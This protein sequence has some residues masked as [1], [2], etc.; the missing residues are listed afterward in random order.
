MVGEASKE[1]VTTPSEVVALDTSDVVEN[2]EKVISPDSV[3]E[4]TR[5]VGKA[6]SLVDEV[7]TTPSFKLL[8]VKMLDG[9]EIS[10]DGVA[11]ADSEVV[12]VGYGILGTGLVYSTLEVDST[13]VANIVEVAVPMT[14]DV[15]S[16]KE[17]VGTNVPL[18]C[19]P[20]LVSVGRPI[21]DVSIEVKDSKVDEFSVVV[22][23]ISDVLSLTVND[24]REIWLL[25]VSVGTGPSEVEVTIPIAEDVDSPKEV[26]CDTS[27]E[28]ST[29]TDVEEDSSEVVT[30]T[31]GKSV[32][33]EPGSLFNWSAEFLGSFSVLRG[34]GTSR[35]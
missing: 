34:S 23:T 5:V 6:D 9:V 25:I 26:V 29:D 18:L 20:V 22:P 31:D 16:S 24:G 19:S 28:I 7:V 21:S 2:A 4:V 11:A 33:E 14:V 17:E 12:I 30:V 15:K 10:L 13:G 32:V 35:R 8:A 1:V 3:S 27:L